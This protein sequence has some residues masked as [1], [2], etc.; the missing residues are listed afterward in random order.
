MNNNF[1]TDFA[2]DKNIKFTE[3][4][5]YTKNNI[6]ILQNKLNKQL[7]HIILFKNTFEEQKI[8][9]ILKKAIINQYFFILINICFYNKKSTIIFVL[10]LRQL[11]Q[12]L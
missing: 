1:R 7:H 8:K 12:Q 6:K 10:P 9:S 4:K 3:I 11:Q 5:T 2:L